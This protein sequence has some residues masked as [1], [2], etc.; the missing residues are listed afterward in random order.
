MKGE[1]LIST[2]SGVITSTLPTNLERNNEIGNAISNI[3]QDIQMYMRQTGGAVGD[4]KKTVLRLGDE[5]EV[6]IV[7]GAENIKAVVKEIGAGAGNAE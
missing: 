5:H 7:V 6:H 1:V 2:Q 3:L 4:L